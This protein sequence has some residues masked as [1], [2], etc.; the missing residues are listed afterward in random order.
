MSRTGKILILLIMVA[1]LIGGAVYLK[2]TSL[3]SDEAGVTTSASDTATRQALLEGGDED[4]SALLSSL[5]EEQ[6]QEILLLQGEDP[7]GPLTVEENLLADD[8]NQLNQNEI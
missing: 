5:D 2:V 4:I 8:I 6:V 1:V 3:S 7:S